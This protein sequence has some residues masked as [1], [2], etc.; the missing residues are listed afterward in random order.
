MEIGLG[1]SGSDDGDVV[2]KRR[3][4]RLRDPLDLRSAVDLDARDVGERVHAGVGAARDGKR[5]PAWKHGGQCF[6]EDGLD[7]ALARL[8]SPAPKAGAVVLER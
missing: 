8:R 4:E 2:G 7:R 6:A 5:L 1:C 3:V